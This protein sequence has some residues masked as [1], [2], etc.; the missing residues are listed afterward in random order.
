MKI[1]FNKKDNMKNICIIVILLITIIGIC[2]ICKYY[3]GTW[4]CYQENIPPAGT[5]IWNTGLSYRIEVTRMGKFKGNYEKEKLEKNEL[6]EL[7]E[8]VEEIK[9]GEISDTYGYYKNG[10]FI[11]GKSYKI[12]EK[13]KDD[14][15]RIIEIIE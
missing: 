6:K 13:N 8:L 5:M 12:D 4:I 3:Y 9:N 11:N 2:F 10:L 1:N 15:Y 7:K 14:Y